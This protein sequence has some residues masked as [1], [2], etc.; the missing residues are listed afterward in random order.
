MKK[1]IYLIAMASLLMF[2][3]AH[4]HAQIKNGVLERL[5]GEQK[6]TT[7]DDMIVMRR[8]GL[9]ATFEAEP[10][11]EPRI[12]GD[13]PTYTL[14][15]YPQEGAD[16][17]FISVHDGNN[18]VKSFFF[19][20]GDYLSIN[21][22]EGVYHVASAAYLDEDPSQEPSK[23]DDAD[24][25]CIYVLDNIEL[26][27][28]TNIYI[29]YNECVNAFHL[30]AL[31]EYGNSM[32]ELEYINVFNKFTLRWH[33]NVRAGLSWYSDKIVDNIPSVRCNNSGDDV[34]LLMMMVADVEGQKSYFIE[35]P[36][37]LGLHETHTFIVST[38]D[39]NVTK[40]GFRVMGEEADM[41]FYHL[42]LLR[43]CTETGKYEL[44]ESL[45]SALGPPPAMP[46]FDPDKPCTIVS[47]VRIDNPMDFEM[48]FNT[49]LMPTVFEWYNNGNFG[50]PPYYNCIRT[51]MYFN[52][53]GDVV[54]EPKPLFRIRQYPLSYPNFFQETPAMK[55]ESSEKMA[56]SGQRTPLAYY[57]PIAFRGDLNPYDE[58]YF[59]GLFYY[60]GENG[61]ERMCDDDSF[62][63]VTV[64][65]EQ[66]YFDSVYIFNGTNSCC[67]YGDPAPVIVEAHNEHLFVNGVLKVNDTRVEFDLNRDD[68][69]PPTMNFL[70]VLDGNGDETVWLDDLTQST[71]VFGCGDYTRDFDESLFVYKGKPQV[72]VGFSPYDDGVDWA[73]LYVY[74]DESLFH[75]NY[76]NV[77]VA[78]LS[79]I[80]G[81]FE[82]QWISLII[83]ITDEEGNSQTQKLMNVFYVGDPVSVSEYTA[84][85]LE[86]EVIPNPFTEEVRIK[87]A[88]PLD[89]A[90][91]VQ[92]YDVLGRRVYDA[93]ENGHAVNEFIIDGSALK[94]SVYFY[95]INTEKGVMRGKIVKN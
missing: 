9:V 93:T 17:F 3:V 85:R 50:F 30:D 34:L 92:L 42:D 15:V 41:R 58:T 78:D 84:E 67:Y 20:M 37:K 64:G 44:L 69:M 18:V 8:G 74:E 54:R 12:K 83:V 70:R 19:T 4:L 33:Y 40:E 91:R 71:L 5:D 49:I 23:T 53:D 61:C 11:A 35:C 72:M 2:S 90:A 32:S 21:L 16:W 25:Y 79:Q 45:G 76:G 56:Y 10:M 7:Y 27:K 52:S 39:W 68:A 1:H 28:D 13:K 6:V 22:E 36:P 31:D 82:E 43:V 80:A 81:L 26:T 38:G 29:D 47:N 57:C 24:Y 77:F 89:G 48:G 73:P 87:S 60:S 94:P 46:P 66:T 59:C 14:N 95:D 62:I 86:H 75:V 63:S 51:E 88:Q 55:V 65:D